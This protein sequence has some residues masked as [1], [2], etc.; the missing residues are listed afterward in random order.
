VTQVADECATAK[1]TRRKRGT[2]REESVKN[3]NNVQKL[4][5]S[6]YGWRFTAGQQARAL[7]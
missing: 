5:L 2:R 3:T 1:G 4:L 7:A 6:R